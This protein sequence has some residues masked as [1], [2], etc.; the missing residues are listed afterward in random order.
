MWFIEKFWAALL[1]QLTCENF[2]E[3]CSRSLWPG[4]GSVVFSRHLPLYR[5]ISLSPPCSILSECSTY[6]K[7][8]MYSLCLHHLS[9][10]HPGLVCLHLS[11]SS[12]STTFLLDQFSPSYLPPAQKTLTDMSQKW[13]FLV[14]N[15]IGSSISL[16]KGQKSPAAREMTYFW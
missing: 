4:Y 5:T 15:P 3:S 8:C 2:M 12:N 9:K 6:V 11:F 7:I 16:L 14:K 1:M 10:L 13:L